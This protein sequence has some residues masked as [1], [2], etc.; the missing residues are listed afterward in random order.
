MEQFKQKIDSVKSIRK[1][2]PIMKNSNFECVAHNTIFSVRKID[3][4]KKAVCHRA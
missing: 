1:K 4:L 2:N 3:G